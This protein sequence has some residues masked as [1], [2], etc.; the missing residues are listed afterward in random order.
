MQGVLVVRNI[1]AAATAWHGTHRTLRKPTIT[2]V[3]TAE[4]SSRR[5]PLDLMALWTVSAQ[6]AGV[7]QLLT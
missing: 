6:L 7:Q 2:C 4:V 1:E 3:S 5:T